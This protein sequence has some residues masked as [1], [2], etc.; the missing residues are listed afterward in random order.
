MRDTLLDA[1]NEGKVITIAKVVGDICTDLGI[2]NESAIAIIEYHLNRLWLEV[3]D[4][5]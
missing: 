5:Y 2:F 4:E 3:R 1:Y